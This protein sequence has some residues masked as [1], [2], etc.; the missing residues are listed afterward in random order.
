M[1]HAFFG[2]WSDIM[3]ILHHFGQE[4]ESI[5]S[6][7]VF[8]TLIDESG[9]FDSSVLAQNAFKCHFEANIVF[10]EICIEFLSAEHLGD[11][12]EL[13]VVIGAFEKRLAVKDLPHANCTMPAIMTAKD[14]I[15][16]E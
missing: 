4:I 7:Q 15:S 16:S 1:F 14:Q 6:R 9:E 11:L 5:R 3:V 12:L 10:V 13:V 8:V 2:T